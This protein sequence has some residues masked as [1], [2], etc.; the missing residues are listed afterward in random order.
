MKILYSVQPRKS[1]KTPLGIKAT[2]FPLCCNQMHGA[3]GAT[4][5][6]VQQSA[7]WTPAWSG[8]QSRIRTEIAFKI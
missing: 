7:E 1:V 2:V 3:H 8:D 4:A 5:Y 6:D